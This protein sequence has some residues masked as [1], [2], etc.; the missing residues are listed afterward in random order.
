MLILNK[1]K[2]LE[3]SVVNNDA[4]I[5]QTNTKLT[6]PEAFHQRFTYSMT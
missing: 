3:I 6:V 5:F 2:K 4:R 1:R